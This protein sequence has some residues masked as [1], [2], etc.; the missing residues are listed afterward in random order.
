MQEWWHEIQ[1]HTYRDQVSFPFVCEK[2]KITPDIC[3]LDINNNQWLKV[4]QH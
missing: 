2:M 3:D 4:C 1:R